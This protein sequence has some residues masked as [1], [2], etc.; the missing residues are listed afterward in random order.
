MQPDYL[1]T[2]SLLLALTAA[3]LIGA[4]AVIRRRYRIACLVLVVITAPHV[5]YSARMASGYFAGTAKVCWPP[6]E[7]RRREEVV[8]LHPKYRA[9]VR[10]YWRI[11]L[12]SLWFARIEQGTFAALSSVLGPMQGSYVGPYPSREAVAR[13]L[14]DA[15]TFVLPSEL[16]GSHSIGGRIFDLSAALAARVLLDFDGEPAAAGSNSL[17]LALIDET[18]LVV[19]YTSWS[20]YHAELV[21]TAGFGWFAHYVFVPGSDPMPAPH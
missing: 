3:V 2:V 19:G 9:F 4:Y 12:W 1:S 6:A 15:K 7:L 16:E 5:F 13:A 20:K 10:P 21:D 8:N 18:C 14:I 11:D 17:A